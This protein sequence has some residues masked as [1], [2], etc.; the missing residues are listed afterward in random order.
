VNWIVYF[1]NKEI[2]SAEF[3]KNYSDRSQIEF[4]MVKFAWK[5]EKKTTI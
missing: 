3:F 4:P 5:F 2:S 1:L